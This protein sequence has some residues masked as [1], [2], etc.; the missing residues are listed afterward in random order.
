MRSRVRACPRMRIVHEGRGGYIE[1]DGRRYAIEH[2]E[3]GRFC[4]HFPSG[5]RHAHRARDRELLAKLAR[6]EPETWAID[7]RSRKP[8][9]RAHDEPAPATP[10]EP[11]TSTPATAQESPTDD[12]LARLV[13]AYAETRD[14]ALRPSIEALGAAEAARRGPIVPR[15]KATLEVA[16]LAV[17]ERCDVGD[18]DRLLEAT[19]PEPAKWERALVRVQAFQRFPSDPRIVHKLPAVTRR[20]ASRRS[21][22]VRATVESVVARMSRRIPAGEAPDS[23]LAEARQRVR[24]TTH[25]DALWSRFWEAPFDDEHRAVLADALQSVGNPR[26]DFIALSIAMAEGR[27]DAATR[28]R[29]SALLAANID[30][31]TGPLAG[32][33]RSSRR[34]DRGFLSHVRVL[35]HD[36]GAMR[37]ALDAP[38][39]R[40]VEH[41]ELASSAYAVDAVDVLADLLARL[42]SLRTLVLGTSGSERLIAVLARRGPFPSIRS[43]AVSDLPPD[44]GAEAFPSL[45]VFGSLTRDPR[46]LVAD[47]R[48]L[49]ARAAVSLDCRDLAGSLAALEES[50]LDELR[51]VF[52]GGRANMDHVG[53]AGRF[54]R[55]EQVAFLHWGGRRYRKGSIVPVLDGL[56]AAG[57]RRVVV[58][59]PSLGRAT[60][61]AEVARCRE[62]LGLEVTFDAPPFDLWRAPDR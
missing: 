59:G 38:E 25:L 7:D 61:V 16:W 36:V 60:L 10:A 37:R 13:A 23:L 44:V 49:G 12:L 2:V 31:W 41:F 34:F 56:A 19:W 48:R 15:S 45:S 53:W 20:Y 52:P 4:I 21:Y 30:V 6:D 28:E 47:A 8:A 24:P 32:V 39:W 18:V 35:M 42:P 17:A 26:G 33:E 57:L 51:F 46:V 58:A 55:G 5:N 3:G 1:L 54:P 40:T 50:P 27:T 29:A 14:E 22:P 11:S 62:A 43:L 9:R